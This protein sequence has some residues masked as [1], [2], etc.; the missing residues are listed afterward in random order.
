MNSCTSRQILQ[1]LLACG[2]IHILTYFADSSGLFFVYFPH[3][4]CAQARAKA[5]RNAVGLGLPVNLSC[6]RDAL[7]KQPQAGSPCHH[8]I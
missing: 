6:R 5:S 4:E 2:N 1:Y 8:I 7:Q 3:T